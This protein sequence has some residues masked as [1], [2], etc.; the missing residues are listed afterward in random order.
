MFEQP[1]A[2]KECDCAPPT[3]VPRYMGTFADLMALLL[4][5]FVLLLSFSEMD[6]LKFKM[7]VRSLENAFGVTTP[8]APDAVPM[9]TSIIQ[10]TFSP[11]PNKPSPLTTLRQSSVSDKKALK[12]NDLEK[13]KSAVRNSQRHEL[14]Q[15]LAPEIAQN[16]V[17]LETIEDRVTIRINEQAAFP[18]GNARL[19][20]GFMPVLNK[21]SQSL[22]QTEADFIVSGHTDDIPINSPRYRS[23]W[24]LSAARA[25]SVVHILLEQPRLTAERFYIKGRG[26]TQPL[27]ANNSLANRAVNRR[28]EISLVN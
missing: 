4:C 24:E 17:S 18:S 7:V 5:F 27:A 25:A 28:V 20:P 12:I 21:I 3:G 19:K 23:N 15:L 1:I 26:S 2:E 13:Y 10:H 16:L 8:E 9:G 11:T 22:A 6:A 14:Q